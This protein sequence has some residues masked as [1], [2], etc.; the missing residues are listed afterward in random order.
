LPDPPEKAC[1]SIAKSLAEDTVPEAERVL[2]DLL[3]RASPARKCQMIAS[4]NL[5]GRAMVG[6]ATRV[7]RVVRID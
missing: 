2:I 1:S 3:R 5:A 6:G 7:T 4:V